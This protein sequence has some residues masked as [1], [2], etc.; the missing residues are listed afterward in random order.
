MPT[1]LYQHRSSLSHGAGGPHPAASPPSLRY[2]ARVGLAKG[3]DEVSMMYVE[4]KPCDGLGTSG[5][6]ENSKESHREP[7]RGN[8]REGD[9]FGI[10]N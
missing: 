2:P 9:M 7:D 4:E 3:T 6:P 1:G 8:L 10:G 5:E